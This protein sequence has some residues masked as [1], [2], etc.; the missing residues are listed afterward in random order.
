V[1]AFPERALDTVAMLRLSLL[2]ISFM[3]TAMVHPIL[4]G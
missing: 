3:V 1:S 2:A 4:I